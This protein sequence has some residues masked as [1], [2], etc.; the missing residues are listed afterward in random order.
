MIQ[1]RGWIVSFFNLFLAPREH[2]E[3]ETCLMSDSKQV[4]TILLDEKL[5]A[6]ENTIDIDWNDNLQHKRR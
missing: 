1:M 5:I 4:H 2:I 6:H 3:T